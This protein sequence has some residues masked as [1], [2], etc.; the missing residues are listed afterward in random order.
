MDAIWGCICLPPALQW[1]LR[2]QTPLITHFSPSALS[3]EPWLLVSFLSLDWLSDIRKQQAKTENRL[4]ECRVNC[5]LVIHWRSMAKKAGAPAWQDTS[6]WLCRV[7]VLSVSTERISEVT[8]AKGNLQGPA[9]T[10]TSTLLDH[11][12]PGNSTSKGPGCKPRWLK[13][14]FRR[15]KK[16]AGW[17]GGYFC[18]K[19]CFNHLHRSM[20]LSVSFITALEKRQITVGNFFFFFYW[21]QIS[22]LWSFFF[23]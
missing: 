6:Y 16:C 11:W 4:Y 20:Y 1:D 23:I 8:P 21:C 14:D 12:S 17:E 10:G 9:G 13:H 2:D 7:G 18:L 22:G 19:V 5:S 3:R 15:L